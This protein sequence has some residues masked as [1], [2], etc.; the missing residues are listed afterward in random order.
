MQKRTLAV[1]GY[2]KGGRLCCL[3]TFASSDASFGSLNTSA[4]AGNNPRT[5]ARKSIRA[6]T[7]SIGGASLWRHCGGRT[8]IVR[9]CESI[10]DRYG[11]KSYMV[12][13]VGE[14]A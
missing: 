5:G 6:L 12:A 2:E 13:R 7:I 3:S 14:L 10:G 11:M 9:R 4:F 8:Q 1:T